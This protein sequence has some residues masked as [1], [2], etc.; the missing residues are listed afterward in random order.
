VSLTCSF[1]A[2]LPPPEAQAVYMSAPCPLRLSNQD[3][4]ILPVAGSRIAVG[5]MCDA[6]GPSSLMVARFH[7]WPSSDAARMMSHFPSGVPVG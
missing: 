3:T 2:H 7:F 5:T 6:Q 4:W 1:G